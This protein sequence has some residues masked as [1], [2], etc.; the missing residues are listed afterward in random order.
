ME[1]QRLQD[2]LEAKVAELGYELVEVEFGGSK[3]RPLM[4]LRIDRPDSG[5]GKGVTIEDCT[6]VSRAVEA[7]LDDREELSERYVLEVSSPGIERPLVRPADYDRFKGKEVAVKSK[8]E[9]GAHG[10]RVEGTLRGLDHGQVQVELASKEVVSVPL[11][12]VVRAHLLF[13]WDEKS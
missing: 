8:N 10:K 3:A 5:P 11:D 1:R 6:A 9:V 13:R 4:R 7:Y 12:D 2:Q